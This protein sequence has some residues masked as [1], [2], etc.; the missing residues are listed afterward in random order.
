MQPGGHLLLRF[1]ISAR[2]TRDEE[3]LR[4]NLLRNHRPKRPRTDV[5]GSIVVLRDLPAYRHPSPNVQQLKHGIRH[6]TTDI[7]EVTVDAI[8]T[9]PPERLIVRLVSPIVQ[10]AVKPSDRM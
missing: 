10:R 9:K 5:F 2:P 7:I 1:R 6:F 4:P 8:R 3:S